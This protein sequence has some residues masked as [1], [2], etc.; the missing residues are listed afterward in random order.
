MKTLPPA[1]PDV[2]RQLR[3]RLYA[4]SPRAFELFSGDMLMYVGLDNV[5]VTRYIGDGG[6]DAEGEMIAGVFRIPVGVQVKRYRHNN[7]VQRSDI[8]QFIGALSGRF[9]QG[10]F[11]TTAHFSAGAQDKAAGT[12]PRI[13]TLN[14]TQ[15]VT[16]MVEHRLGVT[17][18]GG[19]A[20][21]DLALDE[22]YFAGFE[23][24]KA[25]LTKKL[26]EASVRYAAVLPDEQTVEVTPAQDLIS[27]RTLSYA[28]RVDPTTIRRWL[29]SGMLL[30][31]GTS[32]SGAHD[33]YYFQ[34]DR[35]N[36][37]RQHFALDTLPSSSEAWR[38]EFLDFARSRNLTKSYKPVLLQSLVRL[39][40]RNGIVPMDDLVRAFRAFYVQRQQAGVPV[41]F[42]GPLAVNPATVSDSTIKAL[43]VKYPLDRFLIKKYLVYDATAHTVQ[44]AP[45]LW[46]HLRYYDMLDILESA[47]AQIDYYYSRPR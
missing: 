41:E 42:G 44:I 6:I 43:M 30:A 4:L 8:D 47:A 3:E 20:Q 35:I 1:N 18:L 32:L 9:A 36:A 40:D 28:L 2:M 5:A 34:R 19:H 16:T 17:S 46:Q 7:N 12:L 45:Y 22:S 24:Q 33:G 10:I 26:A 39:V 31:D 38:Q 15:L 14:G 27:L 13:H 21:H 29:S 23:D 25:V 11:V 37:I